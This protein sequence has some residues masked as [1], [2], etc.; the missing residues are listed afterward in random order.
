MAGAILGTLPGNLKGYWKCNET[1]GTTLF[2]SSGN[3]NDLTVNGTF[4]TN[5]F[6][7]ETGQD[8][9]CFRTDG[10]AGGASRSTGIISPMNS[11]NFTMIA[12][13]KGSTDWGAGGAVNLSA[14]ASSNYYAFMGNAYDADA[15]KSRGAVRGNA[16]GNSLQVDATLASAFDGAW[17]TIGYRRNSTTF[18]VWVDGVLRGSQTLTLAGTGY[19]TDRTALMMLNIGGSTAFSKGSIQHAAIWNT[20]LTDSKMLQLHQASGL[21]PGSP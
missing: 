4:N 16:S 3:G 5:Y 1:G 10:A 7:N 21:P 18:T 8:G 17:H 13:V 19:T 9:T 2:D 20:N 6:L 11:S 12:L 15:T 14:S